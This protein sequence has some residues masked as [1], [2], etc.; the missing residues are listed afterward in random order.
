MTVAAGRRRPCCAR[1]ASPDWSLAL[2]SCCRALGDAAR[3]RRPALAPRRGRCLDRRCGLRSRDARDELERFDRVLGSAE[4]ISLDGRGR[5]ARRRGRA[6][7]T[8]SSRPRPRVGHE[9]GRSPPAPL[10]RG[11]VVMLTR[12][13]WFMAGTGRGARRLGLGPPQGS[14]H[15]GAAGA[16][17]SSP[18]TALSTPSSGSRPRGPRRHA[19]QGSRVACRP[20]R[21]PGHRVGSDAVRSLHVVVDPTPELRAVAGAAEAAPR[22]SPLALN[23]PA[24][25]RGPSVGCRHD[26][27]R[28]PTT[29]DELRRAFTDFFVARG[30]TVVPSAS[31]IPHD[32][33]VL[34]TDRGHGA[35][36]AVLRRRGDAAVP[37]GR[38]RSQKCVRAGGKHN[39]LD[40]IGRTNRH[41]SVL[42]DARQ[43][44]LRRLLQGRGDPVG[45]GVRT[46]RCSASTPTA[47]GSPST[48]TDDEA[49][50]DLA[51]RGRRARASASSAS[52]TGQLLADG[53]H[54]P[55]RPVLGD[56]L[57][58]GPELR[59]RRRP[60][61]RRRGPL[62]RDLEPRVHAVRP[63]APTARS[64]PLPK[65]SIDTGAGLERNLAVAA[66]RRRRSGTP[67]C[68][69]RSSTAAE[70]VTGDALR[71][72]TTRPTSS[73]RILAEHA[74]TMTFLV[75]DGVFPSNEE[76][77]YVLRRI[78]R[79]AVR[80][81]YLLGVERARHCRAL[82]D[83]TVEVMGDGLPRARAATATSSRGVV[84]REEE[85]FRR[86]CARGLEHARRRARRARGDGLP[87]D[88]RVP[89]A[90]HARLPARP[91]PR[92]RGR[93]R[94]RRRPRRL[95]RARWPSSAARAKDG[96]QG[97]AAPATT[98]VEPTASSLDEF[99]PT[100]FTGREEYETDGRRARRASRRRRRH[101][102][103]SFLD[104][105]PFYAESG[106]QVGDTGTIT[107]DTGRGRR[108]RHART[109]CP[110]CAAT[111]ARVV[112]GDDRRG[113]RGATPRSTATGATRIR[114]NHTATHVLHWALREVLGDARA[115]R[116][117]RSSRPTGCASTS[118]TTSAVT[119]EQLARDRGRSPTRR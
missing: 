12:I 39:D 21:S 11:R 31:L 28:R 37:R 25:E 103:T 35:V 102:S 30:H 106:G 54:R 115:S 76:R 79:R 48:T 52:A 40:D 29:A 8:R 90:R 85:R 49:E 18:R 94:R 34:F 86:R 55:V 47:C 1:S 63:A 5:V 66:G 101:A 112:E 75:A 32:P 98:R 118:A 73:L 19:G 43:L 113:R 58:L 9:A 42:R 117:A 56:L 27:L 14:A 71:R 33:T 3:G 99:G 78:I 13:T 110:A 82:V 46:P 44:Q 116:R 41:F 64:S 57:G 67:T 36:Q 89:P 87:G 80:H 4:A 7:P 68:S 38:P 61:A 72:A 74:R 45:V 109:R 70:A 104:R 51:R 22:R 84:E 2:V 96:A 26:E 20:R 23:G 93:A 111:A 69:A 17:E 119:P 10:A 88:D 62:R 60:G 83:A 95:R 107:T 65:P 59:P 108:A 92:D 81:A 50:A 6:S 91:H 16:A 105:T 97:A 53:R 100:E 77:G 114:R 24:V 15:R